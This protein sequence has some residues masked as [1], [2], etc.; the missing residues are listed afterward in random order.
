MWVHGVIKMD[1]TYMSRWSSPKIAGGKNLIWWAL[2]MLLQLAWN[3]HDYVASVTLG[4]WGVEYEVVR[5][6]GQTALTSFLRIYLSYELA[7]SAIVL[8]SKN[9]FPWANMLF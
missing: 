5:G 6:P 7:F 4:V 9:S 2:G 1:E 3:L 8:T